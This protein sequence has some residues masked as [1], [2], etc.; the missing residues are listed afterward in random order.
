MVMMSTMDVYE[1]FF[2]SLSFKLINGEHYNPW[3]R[4]DCKAL[5]GSAKMMKAPFT[6]I[7]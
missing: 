2:I 4:N 6:S 5:I 3:I 7:S 1:V